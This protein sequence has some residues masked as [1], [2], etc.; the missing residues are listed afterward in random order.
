[1]SA[2]TAV[3]STADG[4]FNLKH[5]FY[6]KHAHEWYG[7]QNVLSHELDRGLAGGP[8]IVSVASSRKK[9]RTNDKTLA[10]EKCGTPNDVQYL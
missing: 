6:Y 7:F 5:G 3:T 8:R 10:N 1:M 2:W 4:Y 9:E